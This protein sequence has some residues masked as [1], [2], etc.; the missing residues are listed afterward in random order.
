MELI[1]VARFNAFEITLSRYRVQMTKYFNQAPFRSDLLI[2]ADKIF[3]AKMNF[4]CA[5]QIHGVFKSELQKRPR[6]SLK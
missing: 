3:E 1:K 2:N 5:Q 6:H 4:G